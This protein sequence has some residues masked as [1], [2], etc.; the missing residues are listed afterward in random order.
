LAWDTSTDNV[1][2][3]S[4]IIYRDGVLL[5]SVDGTITTFQDS[6]VTSDM[7]YT[8]HVEAFDAAGNGSGQSVPL[9][10]IIPST[11]STFTFIAVADS[12]VDESA[13]TTI[14]GTSSLLRVDGSPLRYAYLRFDVEGLPG[15]VTQATLR[16][17][18]NSSSSVGYDV[19][20]VSDNTWDEATLNFTN[21]PTFGPVEA[22]SGSFS[23]GLWTEVD[24][25][26]LISGDG[27]YSLALT[28]P[29]TTAISFGS[30]ESVNPP[31]LIIS[32]GP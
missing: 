12:Y 6:T 18:A 11:P 15:T 5:D 8:Y 20:Q 13:P 1:G 17:Y 31:E 16:V 23:A 30:R 32:V 3:A 9:P 14:R 24:V 21:A 28:T 10:V 4:Y 22:S 19:H 27:T 29:H 26:L 25:T 2:V 7:S